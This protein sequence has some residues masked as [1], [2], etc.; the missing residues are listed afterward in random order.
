[1]LIIPVLL[2]TTI[3]WSILVAVTTVYVRDLRTALP[4]ILQ[5]GLFATPVAY[6]FDVFPRDL[7]GIYSFLNP[8]GPVIDG[9][10]RT[11]LFGQHP[12]FSELGLAAVGA[13]LYF[14]LGYWAFKRME[15]GIADV[16]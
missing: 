12:D 6:G 13:V 5:V 14:M 1:M 8:L 9:L 15:T 4:L 16:A 3:A 10:R 7:R 11:V 2:L